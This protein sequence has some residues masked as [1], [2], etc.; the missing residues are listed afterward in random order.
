MIPE[1]VYDIQHVKYQL[2]MELVSLLGDQSRSLTVRPAIYMMARSPLSPVSKLV[3]TQLE[4][5]SRM[6][7]DVYAIFHKRQHYRGARRAVRLYQ[8]YYGDAVFQNVRLADFAEVG[9]LYEEFQFGP[10]IGWAGNPMNETQGA[11][12]ETDDI[13]RTVNPDTLAIFKNTFGSIWR[14]AGSFAEAVDIAP[15]AEVYSDTRTASA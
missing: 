7:M 8:E 15:G 13:V 12:V 3:W 14:Q 1:I 6:N 2:G 9:N 5:L 10:T 4:T 11:E